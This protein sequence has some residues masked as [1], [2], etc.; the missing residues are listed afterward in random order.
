MV[1]LAHEDHSAV[2]APEMAAIMAARSG[3]SVASTELS[4]AL[5]ARGGPRIVRAQERLASARKALEK[6][7]LSSRTEEGRRG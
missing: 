7:T 1:R 5:L 6:L 4:N 2:V 3:V